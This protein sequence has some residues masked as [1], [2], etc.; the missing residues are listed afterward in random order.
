MKS[1]TTPVCGN[2][3]PCLILA[4]GLGDTR[5][6]EGQGHTVED[7]GEVGLLEHEELVEDG[8]DEAQ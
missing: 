7:E 2:K 8:G 3:D 6:R 4:L 1:E 5:Y